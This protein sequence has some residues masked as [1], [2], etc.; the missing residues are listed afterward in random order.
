MILAIHKL[1][2]S[3]TGSVS[4]YILILENHLYSRR[5]E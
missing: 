1:L 5:K 2:I 3:T 4:Q